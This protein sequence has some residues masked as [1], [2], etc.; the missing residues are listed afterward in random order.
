MGIVVSKTN[1]ILILKGDEEWIFPKGH[2]ELDENLIGMN[3]LRTE[4]GLP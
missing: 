4:S 3:D 1:H 2:V